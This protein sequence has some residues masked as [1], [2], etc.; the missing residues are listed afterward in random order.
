MKMHQNA[1]AQL[2]YNTGFLYVTLYLEI[3]VGLNKQHKIYAA[4]HKIC[5]A[6][7]GTRRN[8]LIIWG[9]IFMGININYDSHNLKLPTLPNQ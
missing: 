2:L 3:L 5:F 1:V 7:F 8:C 9:F 6:Y 4:F